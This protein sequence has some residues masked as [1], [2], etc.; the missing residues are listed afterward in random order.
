MLEKLQKIVRLYTDDE[1]IT[2]TGDMILLTDLGLNSYELVEM[3]CRV[4]EEFD[5]EIPDREISKFKTIQNLLDYI[6]KHV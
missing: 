5:I 2:I 3:V 4:E 6:N 1:A